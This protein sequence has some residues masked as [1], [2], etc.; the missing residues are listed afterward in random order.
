MTHNWDIN[1]HISHFY[2]CK[3]DTILARYWVSIC[4]TECMYS[5]VL[6]VYIGAYEQKLHHS[7]K[8]MIALTLGSPCFLVLHHCLY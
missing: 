4:N 1:Y 3:M 5:A 2:N 7:Y 8:N 6:L